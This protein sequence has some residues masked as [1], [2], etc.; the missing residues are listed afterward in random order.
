MGVHPG[1]EDVGAA[2]AVLEV[3]GVGF[4]VGAL[5]VVLGG[6]V[7]D[8]EAH[9]VV[10]DL[11]VDVDHV[12]ASGVVEALDVV[13]MDEGRLGA[14][15]EAVA[16]EE[17]GLVGAGSGPGVA[18]GDVGGGSLVFAGVDVSTVFVIVPLSFRKNKIVYYDFIKRDYVAPVLKIYPPSIWWT[19]I[20]IPATPQAGFPLHAN[21]LQGINGGLDRN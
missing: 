7:L 3:G 17:G 8:E 21:K 19:K 9:P 1:G 18:F 2:L 15:D 5:D 12:G 10:A 16:D 4:E 14:A 20:P 6:F 11:G 13:G